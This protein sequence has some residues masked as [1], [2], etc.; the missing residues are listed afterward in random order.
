MWDHRTFPSRSIRKY[1]RD[2]L[3]NH[4]PPRYCPDGSVDGLPG[5]EWLDDAAAELANSGIPTATAQLALSYKPPVRE[6]S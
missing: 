4:R 6:A 1:V 3:A 5:M 2:V